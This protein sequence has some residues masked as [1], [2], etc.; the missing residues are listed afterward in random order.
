MKNVT[1]KLAGILLILSLLLSCGNFAQA[2]AAIKLSKRIVNLKMGKKTTL[3]L[4]K[5]NGK[6][7]KAGKIKWSSTNK[8]IAKVS[9]KGVVTGV[10]AGTA[11]ITA[12]YRAK[13]Y[14]CKVTVKANRAANNTPSTPASTAT[15]PTGEDTTISE[16]SVKASDGTTITAKR[17]QTAIHA[18]QSYSGKNRSGVKTLLPNFESYTGGEFIVYADEMYQDE[19]SKGYLYEGYSAMDG[20]EYTPVPCYRMNYIM[21]F[22][23]DT[24]NWTNQYIKMLAEFGFTLSETT[25]NI[26]STDYFLRYNGTESITGDICCTYNLVGFFIKYDM[27]IEVSEYGSYGTMVSFEYPVEFGVE[28]DSVNAITQ[29]TSIASKYFPANNR[30]FFAFGGNMEATEFINLEV[31]ESRLK[32]GAVFTHSDLAEESE[33]ED[34]YC[35]MILKNTRRAE[36]KSEAI[37]LYPSSD[38]VK[39]AEIK[40]LEADSKN[41]A[42]YFKLKLVGRTSHT[43]VYEGIASGVPENK[44]T[45]SVTVPPSITLGNVCSTCY[46]RKICP[47]CLGRKGMSYPTYG[48]SGFSGWVNCAGCNGTGKCWKCGG[49]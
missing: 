21:P 39:E 43:F 10:K 35:V 1:K 40:V 44:S 33:K 42:F 38:K 34:G 37:N 8:K 5:A 27:H 15:P 30:S 36:D 29:D 31:N 13:K 22:G 45:G 14:T 16:Y 6:K 48:Q 23:D 3:K 18:Y 2:K 19:W 41:I 7:I 46:G 49:K 24:K 11:N 26:Y 32:K 47:V 17:G 28:M 25:N 9:K 20:Y 12:K 4:K